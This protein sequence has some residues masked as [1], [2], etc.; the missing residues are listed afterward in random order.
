MVFRFLLGL[1]EP[2]GFTGAVKTI[3]ERFSAPQ[4]GLATSSLGIGTGLGSLIA[5][6]LI[7]FLS[8]RYGW[9]AAFLIASSV[10]AIWIPFAVEIDR[11]IIRRRAD[12]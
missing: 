11:Q 12:C 1:T 4:R 8:L 9:R 3:A 6:P 10:G 7:V 5:P 2:A